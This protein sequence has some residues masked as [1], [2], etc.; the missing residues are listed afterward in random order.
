[1]LI[2]QDDEPLL[3]NADPHYSTT[4]LTNVPPG[5]I[6]NYMVDNKN[7]ALDSV[8][9]ALADPTRR[10]LL[11]SLMN[12]ERTV[13]ELAEP[14]D[15]TLAAVSKH[16]MVLERAHLV[17]KR[18]EGRIQHCRLNPKPLRSVAH[19]LLEY[20]AFWESQFDALEQF[21]KE[22]HVKGKSDAED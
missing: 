13:T 2:L 12:R 14:H 7:A 22:T 10:A 9:L 18:K 19:L 6:F 16:L 4:W 5:I 11:K 15:M 21:M 3:E 17:V 1:M 8:L 20:K